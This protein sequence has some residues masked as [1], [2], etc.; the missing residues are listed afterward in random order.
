MNYPMY[1]ISLCGVLSLL[2][3]AGQSPV[4]S[5]MTG[6]E[7]EIYADAISS[8]SGEPL[9]G[10]QYQLLD[11]L[12]EAVATNTPQGTI[13]LQS[14]FQATEMT[15]IY[16]R[17]SDTSLNLGT[18]SFDALGTGSVTMTAKTE[19]ETGYTIYIYDDGDLR[20]GDITIDDVADGS[21]TL[22]QEEY[23]IGLQGD[24]RVSALDLPIKQTPTALFFRTSTAP[25]DTGTIEFKASIGQNS[26]RGAYSHDVTFTMVANP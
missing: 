5:Q 3:F 2:L 21:V 22:G 12:G 20:D 24:S 11:T 4:W 17:L 14:G 18:L 7:Y 15:G 9:S 16:F 10:G 13:L 1:V 8:I 25:N 26:R 19:S 6:G 23:G